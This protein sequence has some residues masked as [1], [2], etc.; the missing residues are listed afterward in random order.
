MMAYGYLA[1]YGIKG[2]K[3]GVR[4][5]Q[6]PDGSL[7]ELGRQHYGIIGKRAAEKVAQMSPDNRKKVYSTIYKM[8][9]RK[10]NFR[11]KHEARREKV[12]NSKGLKVAVGVAAVS[13]ALLA[14]TGLTVGGALA[15]SSNPEAV[16]EALKTIGNVTLTAAKAAGKMAVDAITNPSMAKELAK[17]FIQNKFKT[18][19]AEQAIYGGGKFNT[20]TKMAKAVAKY[21]TEEQKE[22]FVKNRI[23][24]L[25]GNKAA[26]GTIANTILKMENKGDLEKGT[27]SRAVANFGQLNKAKSGAKE[28]IAA[29]TIAGTVTTAMAAL[30]KPAIDLV[31]EV[32]KVKNAYDSPGGKF[33][34]QQ[35]KSIID[36]MGL[37]EEEL[38]KKE[39]GN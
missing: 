31:N 4:R 19:K 6:N 34:R 23:T 8:E 20:L 37:N 7:T 26:F 25:K 14:I 2:Q 36:K 29:G 32:T 28:A 5:Y 3:W 38:K 39:G 35:G 18:P 22:R 11:E 24:D 12:L 27:L 1:H 15:I 13:S 21:G 30:T 16:K 33:I 10:Q 17:E 9:E